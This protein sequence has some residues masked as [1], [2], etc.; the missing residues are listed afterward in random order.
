MEIQFLGHSAFRL[1]D[2]RNEVL[3]DPFL[4]NNPKAPTT[5]DELDATTIL[6]THGHQDH[7]GDAVSIAKRTGASI[8]VLTEI[9]DEIVMKEKLPVHDANLG[10]TV[11]FEWGWAKLVPA[12]HT[13]TTD[14]G[15]ASI[16]AGLLVEFDGKLIYHLGD[17]C[18]FSDM[19]LVAPPGRRIDVALMPIGG[20]YTMDRWDAVRAVQF[21]DPI[22][23]VP[24]HY[25]TFPPIQT[26]AG[27][28][29]QDVEEQTGTK[30][31]IMEPGETHKP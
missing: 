25:D 24:M 6:I 19:Q 21:I 15:T 2:G 12:I 27:A 11:H 9:A 29:K 22:V 14:A 31:V 23:A 28:F 26:D 8:V 30:V 18:L 5:A 17:T 4:T 1:S 13:S 3:I 20:H 10:G 7:V 16:A